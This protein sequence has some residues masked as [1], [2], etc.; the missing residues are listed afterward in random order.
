MSDDVELIN[1]AVVLIDPGVFHRIQQRLE[2]V[3]HVPLAIV[4][5]PDGDMNRETS[6]QGGHLQIQANLRNRLAKLFSLLT[7]EAL[8]ARLPPVMVN[9]G[10]IR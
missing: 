5:W 4:G 10:R 2:D 8:L 1:L 9:G 7:N 3:I 6:V